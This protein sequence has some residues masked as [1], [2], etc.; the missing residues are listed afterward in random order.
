MGS[1]GCIAGFLKCIATD[2]QLI[3]IIEYGNNHIYSETNQ[4]EQLGVEENR[5]KICIIYLP[6]NDKAIGMKIN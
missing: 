1:S 6:E 3:R 5:T 4:T 2:I